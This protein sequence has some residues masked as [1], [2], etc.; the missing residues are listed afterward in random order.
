MKNYLLGAF[1]V[2]LLTSC[3]DVS[4]SASATKR[5]EVVPSYEY[6]ECKLERVDYSITLMNSTGT[7][8]KL[9][10]GDSTSSSGSV[11]SSVRS[12]GFY[13]AQ[14]S[15]RERGILSITVKSDNGRWELISASDCSDFH[16]SSTTVAPLGAYYLVVYSLAGGE[17]VRY[18]FEATLSSP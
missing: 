13:V 10:I 16:P 15:I 18:Y 2:L 8:R 7:D 14:I 5:E 1:V 9:R 17:Q 6:K 4:G 3:V 11:R 12:S